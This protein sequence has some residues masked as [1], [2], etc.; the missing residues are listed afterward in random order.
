MP[1]TTYKPRK[2]LNPDCPQG[3]FNPKRL[4]QRFC[5]NDCRS[6]FHFLKKREERKNQ[7]QQA[8]NLKKVSKVLER[9]FKSCRE[10]K[11]S[12]ISD[13]TLAVE[14]VTLNCATEITIHSQYGKVHWFYDFGLF[15]IKENRFKI[16][17]KKYETI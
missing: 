13:E 1:K 12:S 8:E 17:N 3:N 9:F 6:R 16:I 15:L 10:K 11:I 7:Y 5:D 14:N 4:D 2:C